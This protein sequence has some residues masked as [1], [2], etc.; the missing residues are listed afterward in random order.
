MSLVLPT[1]ES[2]SAR[3]PRRRLAWFVAGSVL[4]HVLVVVLWHGEPPAGP[5][6]QGTF[7]I[8]LV[9]R[10]GDAA[11]KP[12]A[13]DER[14]GR[15]ESG[16]E[17]QA[18]ALPPAQSEVSA[19]RQQRM[20]LITS[21]RVTPVVK[22]VRAGATGPLAQARKPEP[23]TPQ[24]EK[25]PAT[26]VHA[27]STSGGLAA[28]SGATTHG[29]HELTS[30]ARYRRVRDELLRA[31]LPHF[32]YPSIARRRGW[33][34]RVRIGLLVEADGDLSDVQLIESSGYGLL[35]KAAIK[36]VNKLRNVPAATQWLDGH[37]MGV[38]L[39]VSYRLED[40]QR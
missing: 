8:T 7:Q 27:T 15:G 9:A 35:D 32:E 38:I 31:L 34:G 2:R 11:E 17:A 36:N 40:R 20:S 30:A 3:G 33:E 37:D 24:K 25:S 1:I 16:Q 23:E 4:L 6:G 18:A 13:D 19:D 29:Q 21:R 22:N 10:H 14:A 28:R 39:P 5:M 12:G 26:N